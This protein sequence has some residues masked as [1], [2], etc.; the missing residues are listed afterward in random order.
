MNVSELID[1]LANYRGD[2]PVVCDCQINGL[3]IAVNITTV[4]C[5]EDSTKPDGVVAI[6][7][8]DY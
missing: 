6:Q 3:T 7:I 5:R 1:K 8:E 2:T 4:E